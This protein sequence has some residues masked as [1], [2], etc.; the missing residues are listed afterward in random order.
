MMLIGSKVFISALRSADYAHRSSNG[1]DLVDS[2][3]FLYDWPIVFR[4]RLGTCL[5]LSYQAMSSFYRRS[6]DS[7]MVMVTSCQSL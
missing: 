2:F 6:N 1:R 3:C 5:L 7:R 4:V